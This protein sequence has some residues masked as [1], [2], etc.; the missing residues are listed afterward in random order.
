MLQNIRVKDKLYGA[1]EI[2]TD[3]FEAQC[4]L[5]QGCPLSPVLFRF[6]INDLALKMNSTNFGVVCGE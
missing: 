4:G 2:N 1:L 6:F 5:K 3:W